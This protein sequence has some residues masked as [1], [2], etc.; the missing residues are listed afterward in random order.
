MLFTSEWRWFDDVLD[1][2]AGVSVPHPRFTYKEAD[3]KLTCEL[4]LPGVKKEILTLEVDKG[5]LLVNGKRGETEVREELLIPSRY[6]LENAKA[7][8]ADGVLTLV[9]EPK[10]APEKKLL[11]IG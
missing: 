7:T 5:R 3:G 11:P 9:F 2:M 10:Q 6:D 4:D 1:R 8:L